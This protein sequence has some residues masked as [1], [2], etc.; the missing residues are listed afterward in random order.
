MLVRE[1]GPLE[2]VFSLEGDDLRDTRGGAVEFCDAGAAYR[3]ARVLKRGCLCA[4]SG[5]LFRGRS[6]TGSRSPSTPRRG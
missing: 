3:G 1:P 6:R 4:R 2:R 5:S